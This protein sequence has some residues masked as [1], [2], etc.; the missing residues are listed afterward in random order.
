MDCKAFRKY[1]GAFADGELE[2]EQNLDALEH[3]NM[4]PGCAA[5]ANAVNSLKAALKRVFGNFRTP[6][7]VRERVVQALEAEAEQASSEAT[8][9]V[10]PG[11]HSRKGRSSIPLGMAAALLLA[12]V[13]WQLW[14]RQGLSMN[15]LLVVPGQVAAEVRQQHRYCIGHRGRKHYDVS[16]SRDLPVIAERLSG[17]L[18]MKV[19]APDLSGL[20]FELVGADSCGVNKRTGAHVVYWS[21]SSGKLLSVFTVA[22]WAGMDGEEGGGSGD[23]G[24]FVSSADDP[25]CIVAWHQGPQTYM[26]CADLPEPVLL[27]IAGRVSGATA[28][29]TGIHG[30]MSPC[31][32][33][34]VGSTR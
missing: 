13:G 5:R 33:T 31:L 12:V 10:P 2:V 30:D 22:R 14:P 3:L 8:T 21:V 28:S 18:K 7:H 26:L 23:R 1:I 15:P 24:F 20:G 6:Q 4:C 19:I 25:L 17:R 32:A 11:V 34:T 9:P 16:L 27:E 29:R